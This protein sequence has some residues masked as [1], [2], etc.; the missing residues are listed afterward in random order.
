MCSS[1]INNQQLYAHQ[2][3]QLE[4]V[5]EQLLSLSLKFGETLIVTNADHLWVTESTRQFAPRV[6]T[7]LSRIP[8]I[9]ARVKYEGIFPNDVFAWKRE[10][11]REII[12]VRIARSR[13]GAL[14][15]LVVLGDSPSEM[16]AAHSSTSGVVSAVKTVKFKESP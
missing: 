4:H 8:I 9:S 15:N 3:Q 12:G 1:A 6:A 10:T 7:F 2:A 14:L 13:P 5:L 16:E 11:F